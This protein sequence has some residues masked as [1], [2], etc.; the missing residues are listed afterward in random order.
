MCQQLSYTFM[1]PF[2]DIPEDIVPL[3]AHM[4]ELLNQATR[5]QPLLICLDSVD[6]LVGSQDG[7]KMSWLPTK[8]PP[9][10]KIIVSCTKEE[11]NPLLCQDYELLTKMVEEKQNFLEVRALGEDLAWK[12][13]KLWMEADGRD[14]NNY[15]WRVVANAVAK[16]S[17][18]IFCKLVFAEICRWKSYSKPQVEFCT[19]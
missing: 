1:L 5:D 10:C 6:Q 11:N 15:Q 14:L 7:N 18:P 12:V 9:H 2:E 19:S 13:I 4:K 3:T 17:L 16:C 8:L